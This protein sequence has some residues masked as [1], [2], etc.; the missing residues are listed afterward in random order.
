MIHTNEEGKMHRQQLYRVVGFLVILALVMGGAVA[1]A[2]RALAATGPVRVPADAGW[3]ETGIE[4][5]GGEEVYLKTLGVAIT[6]PLQ[7]YP[8]AIS[9]PDGQEWNLGCGQYP[10]AP[11]DCAMDDAFYGA[12]VGKVGSGDPFVVGGA[13]SFTPPD[14]GM[15]YLAVNDN[16]IYYEDNMAGFTV[17]FAGR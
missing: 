5:V 10:G 8:G 13:L 17:L 16:L 11:E 7:W 3:V 14:T 2:P 12:L 1:T 6:G 4:V 9:G 15:L